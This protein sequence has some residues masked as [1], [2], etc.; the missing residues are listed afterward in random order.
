MRNLG[1]SLAVIF[2]LSTL[3]KADPK[4]IIGPASLVYSNANIPVH[5]DA[6]LS[7]VR[8]DPATIHYYAWHWWGVAKYAGTP[9]KPFETHIGDKCLDQAFPHNPEFHTGRIYAFIPSIYVDNLG[10]YLGFVH[11]EDGSTVI[12]TYND[13]RCNTRNDGVPTNGNPYGPG[14][15]YSIGLAYSTDQGETWRFLGHII[16]PNHEN[17]VATNIGGAPYIVKDG[18][19]YCYFNEH[20]LVGG[21]NTR[22]LSV[23]R[24]PVDAVLAAARNN[25]VT[26]WIK[27]NSGTGGFNLEA[28]NGGPFGVP[29]G[30]ASNVIPA[31]PSYPMTN[32]NYYDVHTDA[33]YSSV[34]K[35]YLLLVNVIFSA[36]LMYSSEDGVTWSNYSIIDNTAVMNYTNSGCNCT[37]QSSIQH[38]FPTISTV[39]SQ[40]GDIHE[41]GRQFYVIYPFKPISPGDDSHY[42]YDDLY[43]K[44][45]SVTSDAFPSK[46][47]LRP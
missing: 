44:K 27:Y 43:V 38:G 19:F 5:I 37:Q 1:N 45:V 24:A 25:Q 11:V 47:M 10:N 20:V 41:V 2:A 14:T 16:R 40:A 35:K 8:V 17:G 3:A 18:Y 7:T 33:V 9:E 26:Q 39:S 21:V 29:T 32:Q 42:G 22:R 12:P 46:L 13:T 34:L 23:A 28:G 31:H 6:T 15:R 30:T 36:T 4:P